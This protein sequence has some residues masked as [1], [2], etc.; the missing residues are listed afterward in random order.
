[1][2]ILAA[3]AHIT[4]VFPLKTVMYFEFEM[5]S[6]LKLFSYLNILQLFSLVNQSPGYKTGL[7]QSPS[8]KTGLNQSPGYKTGI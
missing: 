4:G 6:F 2:K 3:I 7:N 8:Y 1:M 5:A